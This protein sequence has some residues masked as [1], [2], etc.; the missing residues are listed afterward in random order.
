MYDFEPKS[1]YS[2]IR[3]LAVC[4]LMLIVVLNVVVACKTKSHF[5]P[6]LGFGIDANEYV[7]QKKELLDNLHDLILH[8]NEN[9]KKY[10][11]KLGS[12]EIISSDNIIKRRVIINDFKN[13]R[14]LLFLGY[15]SDID[16]KVGEWYT[17][18]NSPSLEALRELDAF[19][20]TKRNVNIFPYWIYFNTYMSFLERSCNDLSI[21]LITES[22]E[23]EETIY[24]KYID[25]YPN[26]IFSKDLIITRSMSLEKIYGILKSEPDTTL[27]NG[28]RQR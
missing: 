16:L 15:L 2:R 24:T 4:I 11:N 8:S 17:P 3:A 1:R 21:E 27:L 10:E 19:Y 22:D 13:V 9:I 18:H 23:D 28:P 12:I 5:Y 7:R 26:R 20:L 14:F 25:K 6:N